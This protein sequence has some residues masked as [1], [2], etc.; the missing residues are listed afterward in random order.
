MQAL[1]EEN[2]SLKGQLP[3]KPQAAPEST[4]ITRGADSP[5]VQCDNW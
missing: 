2:M 3:K 5:M 1:R 4:F